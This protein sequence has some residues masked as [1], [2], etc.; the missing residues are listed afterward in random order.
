M[1]KVRHG[2]GHHR[3]WL[4]LATL[5]VAGLVATVAP[6][7]AQERG[8]CASLDLEWPVRL[9]DG[10]AYRAKSLSLCLSEYWTPVV[11]L[12]ELKVD[13]QTIGRFMSR[14]GF[15][16]G[17]AE[18]S[19]VVVFERDSGDTWR[20][21]GYAWPAGDR[22][23]TFALGETERIRIGADERLHA[24]LIQSDDGLAIVALNQ[25]R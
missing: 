15:S 24:A 14:V 12:H 17:P 10:S 11:G 22:M 4:G 5:V 9:P 19:P 8:R 2:V 7:E 18:R 23:R 21:V 20:L 3:R 25:P 6:V 13:G 16:E 1:H